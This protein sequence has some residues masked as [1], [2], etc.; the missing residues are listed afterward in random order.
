[1]AYSLGTTL[2]AMA[3]SR[4]DLPDALKNLAQEASNTV[5]RPPFE[6]NA[7]TKIAEIAQGLRSSGLSFKVEDVSHNNIIASTAGVSVTS[8]NAPQRS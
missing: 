8:P 2:G 3:A 1:M 5:F 7:L 6:G 4:G